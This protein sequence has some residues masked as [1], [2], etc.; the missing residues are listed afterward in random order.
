MFTFKKRKMILLLL[1]VGVCIAGY[2]RFESNNQSDLEEYVNVVNQID[3]E[4]ERTLGEAKMASGK[5][6]SGE[7]LFA[8]CKLER[9]ESRSENIDLLTNTINNSNTTDDAKIKAEEMLINISDNIEKE[10]NIENIIKLKG[11][12]DVMAFVDKDSVTITVKG[13]KLTEPQVSQI[14]DV[15][16]EYIDTKNVKIVEVE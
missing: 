14:Y 9:D 6:N 12:E 13:K 2:L 10:I 3:A 15:I 8:K 5:I 1:A 7:N 4:T 16:N 11:F